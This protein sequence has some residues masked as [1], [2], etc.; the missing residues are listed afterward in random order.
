[1][2]A[3]L[4]SRLLPHTQTSVYA[5]KCSLDRSKQIKS[6]ADYVYL[7]PRQQKTYA[8][9]RQNV[10]WVVCIIS[11]LG[12]RPSIERWGQASINDEL[13]S[14][15]QQ[16]YADKWYDAQFNK[17]LLH[18]SAHSRSTNRFAWSISQVIDCR[19][20]LMWTRAHAYYA[21]A[22]PVPQDDA[23]VEPPSEA[24]ADMASLEAAPGDLVRKFVR[25]QPGAV[26]PGNERHKVLPFK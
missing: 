13:S 25:V 10:H 23:Q 6:S 19:R 20:I 15:A 17:R 11:I 21:F 16:P 7:Q 5:L 14:A 22:P 1:M 8:Y 24:S 4:G 18:Q 26:L 2:N 3:R 12:Y 9:H